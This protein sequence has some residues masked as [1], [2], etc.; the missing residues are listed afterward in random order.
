M[1][2][3]RYVEDEHIDAA[4]EAVFEYRLDYAANLP[5]YNPNVSKMERTDGGFELGVGAVYAFEVEI[6]DM[7]SM[8][9]TLTVTEVDRPQRIVNVMG[10][11]L[12]VAREECTFTQG[13]GGTLVAFEVTL[14]FPE[15]MAG[16]AEMA[17]QSGREQV[18][19]ELELMK[20]A[21]E[22]GS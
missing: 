15:E 10:S 6:P 22:G 5:T 4:P 12:I 18:R 16:I 1:P 3:V 20:K 14:T 13:D 11:G 2:E 17:E 8:P 21:L 9:T 19:I 7:G